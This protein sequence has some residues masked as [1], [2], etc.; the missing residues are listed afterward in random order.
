[1]TGSAI[2]GDE[3]EILFKTLRQ[4]LEEYLHAHDVH[5]GQDEVAGSPVLWTNRAIYVGVFADNLGWNIRP[6]SFGRPAVLRLV[7]APKTR[8]I[9]EKDSERLA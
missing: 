4:F 7:D 3:Q 6:D 2:T 5:C 1:M 8:F 9:L